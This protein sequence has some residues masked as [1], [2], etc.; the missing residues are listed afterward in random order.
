M[1]DEN[2]VSLKEHFAALRAADQAALALDREWVQERLAS[3][4]DL[5]NKWRDATERDR[6]NFVSIDQFDALRKEFDTYRE[7]TAKALTLAEG[8]SR[9]V[10][11]VRT[12][13]SFVAGVAI[14]LLAAWVA[15]R[16]I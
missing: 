10:D 3:H 14:A 2:T 5:L 16:G 1:P 12:A 7:I 15:F 9:G 8:K 13:V 11:S 6:G 4:N